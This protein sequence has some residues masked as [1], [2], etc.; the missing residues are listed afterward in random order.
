ML[1]HMDHLLYQY[2]QNYLRFLS[3][4]FHHQKET[5]SFGAEN[6]AELG[7]AFFNVLLY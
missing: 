7:D 6:E 1:P 4:V 3:F 2:E 5:D